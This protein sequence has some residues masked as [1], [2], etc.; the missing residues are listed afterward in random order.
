MKKYFQ[1]AKNTWDE[2]LAYRTSFILYRTRGFLQLLITYFVW[3]YI[4]TQQGSFFGYSQSSMLT[5][6]IIGSFVSNFIFATRTTSIASEINEGILTNF[7]IRPFSYI[8]YHFARDFGDKAMN[9]IFT[10]GELI[11]FFLIF[12]P[13]FIFQSNCKSTQRICFGH[14][15]RKKYKKETKNELFFQK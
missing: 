15:N 1:I 3:Q 9:L 11:V 6:I 13:P 2:T 10:I 5:Y 14:N 12:H 8:S 4:T 7:L